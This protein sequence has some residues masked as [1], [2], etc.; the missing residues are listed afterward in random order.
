MLQVF[1]RSQ[2]LV[3]QARPSGALLDEKPLRS[4]TTNQDS[5]DSNVA[6]TEQLWWHSYFVPSGSSGSSYTS[7][8]STA[9]VCG[10][11][12]FCS[13]PILLHVLSQDGQVL[14][15][16]GGPT[17]SNLLQ[18]SSDHLKAPR[19][20]FLKIPTAG[21]SLEGKVIWIELIATI[22]CWLSHRFTACLWVPPF[23]EGR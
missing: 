7:F 16:K 11:L 4:S 23:A 3:D 1:S 10:S 12:M 13:D 17:H 21:K 5:D 19:P 6:E 22:L 8:T 14:S 9:K 20:W 2:P 18:H 15:S